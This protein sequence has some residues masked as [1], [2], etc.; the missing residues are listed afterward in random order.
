[1]KTVYFDTNVYRHIYTLEDGI[2]KED[3]LKLKALIRADKIRILASIEVVEETIS[4]IISVPK[5]A[6]Q[7]LKLIHKLAKRKRMIKHHT[8][9]IQAVHAYAN[10]G[11]VHS[12]FS[13]PPLLMR[14]FLTTPNLDD[15][16]QIARET[17]EQIQEHHDKM[18][19]IYKTKIEPL[20]APVRQQRQQ[21]TFAD[22]WNTMATPYLEELARQAEVLEKCQARGLNGLLAIRCLHI[23][24]LGQVSLNYA[25]TYTGRTP[26]RSDSRDMHH[27]LVSSAAEAFITNDAPLRRVM[28][29]MPV[30]GYE[31][32]SF[33][34]MMA[35]IQ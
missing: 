31:A 27:V 20:A 26:K 12:P 23:H 8:E 4:A 10:G 14:K 33:K 32:L 15:L 22:Y 16:E 29:R 2:T 18:A 19:D 13:S 1:M 34:E 21:P 5:E 11:K 6:V 35:K 17:Q 28:N 25:N 30:E 9:F 3:I 7:R 24:T